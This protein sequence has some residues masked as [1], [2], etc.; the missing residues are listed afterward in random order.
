MSINDISLIA[1]IA[2][3]ILAIVAIWLS[4]VFYRLSIEASR[5]S[6]EAAN[7][8][9]SNVSRLDDLFNRL[10]TDNFSLV[11]DTFTDMRTRAWST[12]DLASAKVRAEEQISAKIESIRKTYDS[13]ILAL[14]DSSQLPQEKAERITAE[15]RKALEHAIAGTRLAAEEGHMH[16]SVEF[17]LKC[18]RML[19]SSREIVT[20]SDIVES[21]ES[22]MPKLQ[23]I[24][25]LNELRNQKAI[26]LS[27]DAVAPDSRVKIGPA[28]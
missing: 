14:I 19:T 2:S 1:S 12:Q 18:T 6:N 7:R 10:Y 13:K 17:V 24:D 8:I 27:P 20:V 25:I 28:S 15:L 5:S 9:S 26:A 4:I 22:G 3:L 16:S 21:L 23:I 11:R